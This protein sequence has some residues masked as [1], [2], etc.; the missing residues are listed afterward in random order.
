MLLPATALLIVVLC[1]ASWKTVI[2]SITVSVLGFLAYPALEYA[3][4]KKWMEF[5]DADKPKVPDDDDDDDDDD[6]NINSGQDLWIVEILE[7]G[8]Y[9]S[10]FSSSCHCLH[11]L[12]CLA[13]TCK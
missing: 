3:K 11:S 7:S 6:D 4:A 10:T 13:P 1:L 12:I 2:F 8:V 9:Y 5:L